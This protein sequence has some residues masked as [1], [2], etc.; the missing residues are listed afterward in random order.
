MSLPEPE[1]GGVGRLSPKRGRRSPALTANARTV[2][3]I[4]IPRNTIPANTAT[5][6]FQISN[7]PTPMHTEFGC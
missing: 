5:T 7:A 1:M 6:V 4:A 3:A 2:N